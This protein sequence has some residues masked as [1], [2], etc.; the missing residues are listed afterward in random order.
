MSSNGT[1]EVIENWTVHPTCSQR[2]TTWFV[3]SLVLLSII[4]WKN[5]LIACSNTSSW[6][7]RFLNEVEYFAQSFIG[8]GSNESRLLILL[9]RSW[10]VH[11]HRNNRLIMVMKLS[12]LIL[13]WIEILNVISTSK[14][15]LRACLLRQYLIPIITFSKEYYITIVISIVIQMILQLI[16]SC[17]QLIMSLSCTF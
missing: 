12:S 8:D 10:V 2:S 3:V 16:N 5:R 15:I 7:R 11:N 17:S 13:K 6:H 1:L 9:L 4:L 14:H